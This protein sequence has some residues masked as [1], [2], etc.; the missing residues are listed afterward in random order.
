MCVEWK[1]RGWNIRVNQSSDGTP[2]SGNSSRNSSS[3]SRGGS[4]ITSNNSTL[5][6][7]LMRLSLLPAVSTPALPWHWHCAKPY[8]EGAHMT[9]GMGRCHSQARGSRE[10]KQRH[11][12]I[13][14][15]VCD[16]QEYDTGKRD[17]KWMCGTKQAGRTQPSIPLWSLMRSLAY[18]VPDLHGKRST[19]SLYN[20]YSTR[21]RRKSI[22]QNRV[23]NHY[24]PYSSMRKVRREEEKR[25]VFRHEQDNNTNPLI[26]NSGQPPLHRG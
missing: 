17:M 14:S 8:G 3:R 2:R 7:K 1:E 6:T 21:W 23:I 19:N 20:H 16:D 22:R 25:L 18:D 26:L 15:S 10:G 11:A 24:H 12:C 5:V 4:I 13:S 9:D